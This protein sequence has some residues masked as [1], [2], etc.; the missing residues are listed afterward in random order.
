MGRG[1][2]KCCPLSYAIK[3]SKDECYKNVRF[4]FKIIA[5]RFTLLKYNDIMRAINKKEG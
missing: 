4:I 2:F 5:K 1:Q 3:T